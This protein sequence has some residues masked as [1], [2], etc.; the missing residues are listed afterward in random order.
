[1]PTIHQ[2]LEKDRDGNLFA[3]KVSVSIA[4]LYNY[5][6]LEFEQSPAQAVAIINEIVKL[7]VKNEE[8]YVKE[9]A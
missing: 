9:Y 4:T 1:M 5:L 6:R 3:Q 7:S 2:Y 8:V